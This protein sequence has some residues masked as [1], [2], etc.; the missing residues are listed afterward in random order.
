V[1]DVRTP[2]EFNEDH[3]SGTL[4]IPLDQLQ[5]NLQKLDKN[6]PVILCCASGGRSEMAK[7]IL[8]THGFK[9]LLNVGSWKN[10]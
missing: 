3:A 5:F 2:A 4:N 8:E 6:K 9:E 7:M 1:V 10:L